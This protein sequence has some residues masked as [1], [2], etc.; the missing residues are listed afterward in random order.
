MPN[1]KREQVMTPPYPPG[2]SNFQAQKSR[3]SDCQAFDSIRKTTSA[4][5]QMNMASHPTQPLLRVFM[6][7]LPPEFHFGLLGWKGSVNQTWP[8]V[9]NPKHIPSYPGGLNLQHSME[10]WLTLDLL[11]SSNMA[12]VGQPCTA[13]RVKDSSQADVIFVP[14]FSSL[15]WGAG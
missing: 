1:L 15:S 2:D 11:S 5:Q 14:F 4:G 10:Y 7:D 13:I 9:D 12:K 8:D 6:Y 3:E